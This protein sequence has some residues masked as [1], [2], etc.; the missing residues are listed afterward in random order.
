MKLF[1]SLFDDINLD[2]LI[3]TIFEIIPNCVQIFQQMIDF[4]AEK[5]SKRI[6]EAILRT[7]YLLEQEKQ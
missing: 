3:F 6:I 7:Y 4:P 5:T 1:I 2:S